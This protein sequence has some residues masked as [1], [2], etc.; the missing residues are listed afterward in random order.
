[1]HPLV[2]SQ[3]ECECE[4]FG[5]YI[6]NVGLFARRLWRFLFQRRIIFHV[7]SLDRSILICAYLRFHWICCTRSF[8][9]F[10][11][12]PPHLLG[13]PC[14]VSFPGLPPIECFVTFIESALVRSYA[15]VYSRVDTQF[16]YPREPFAAILNES[17]GFSV[18]AQSFIFILRFFFV[19]I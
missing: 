10:T 17:A 4:C 5:T 9:L 7:I 1:M 2:N 18:I 8:G 13:V 6:A 11:S 14:L 16:L 12:A 3:L 19:F 15:S